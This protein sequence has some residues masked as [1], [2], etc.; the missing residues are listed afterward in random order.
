MGLTRGRMAHGRNGLWKSEVRK[1]AELRDLVDQNT[2]EAILEA[3]R[4]AADW[5]ASAPTRRVRRTGA[6]RGIKG[7]FS[8]F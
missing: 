3:Q 4:Q 6:L 1:L 7:I 8:H 2:K 5:V